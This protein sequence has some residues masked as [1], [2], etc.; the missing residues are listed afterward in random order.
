MPAHVDQAAWRRIGSRIAGSGDGLEG[1]TGHRQHEARL[2][3]RAHEGNAAHASRGDASAEILAAAAHVQ[4]ELNQFDSSAATYRDPTAHFDLVRCGIAVYGI[5]P[6]PVRGFRAGIVATACGNSEP[7]AAGGPARGW[8]EWPVPRPNGP[9]SWP[10]NTASTAAALAIVA[11]TGETPQAARQREAP[12]SL[13]PDD[14][15]L[16]RHPHGHRH[17]RNERAHRDPADSRPQPHGAHPDPFC[18]FG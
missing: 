3:R 11:G 16:R 17:A 9:S 15:G 18:V 10:S 8:A 1:G 7:V 14:P 12:L 13:R 2:G 5:P 6:A 4:F